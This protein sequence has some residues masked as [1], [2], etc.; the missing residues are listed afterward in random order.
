MRIMASQ[1]R[2]SSSLDS[3]S[4]GS[5]ISVPATGND[6][7]GAWKPK[8]I[9][10]LATSSTLMP[11]LSFSGRRSRMHSCATRPLLPVYSTG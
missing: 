1:K 8:S 10:R 3:L 11:L 4:V 6:M 5:I 2:S 9:R 7:V